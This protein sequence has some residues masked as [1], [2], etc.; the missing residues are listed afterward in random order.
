M[1]AQSEQ[2]D[3]AD[4]QSS[5][6]LKA[7]QSFASTINENRS[8]DN[9]TKLNT[10]FSDCEV[11]KGRAEEFRKKLWNAQLAAHKSRDAQLTANQY[12]PLPSNPTLRLHQLVEKTSSITPPPP[13]T[14]TPTPS[15][16]A[17]RTRAGLA[18]TPTFESQFSTTTSLTNKSV[19]EL[20]LSQ[21]Q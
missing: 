8:P 9:M 7:V 19:T 10:L 12:T 14:I 21:E 17:G 18:P 11:A 15:R 4:A 16:W 20:K 2:T 6:A 5:A 13:A 1:L 3:L